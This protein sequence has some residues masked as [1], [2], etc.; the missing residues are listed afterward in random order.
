MPKNEIARN[1]IVIISSYQ[2]NVIENTYRRKTPRITP[3]VIAAIKN[4]HQISVAFVKPWYN[5]FI[6]ILD[7][8]CYC[9]A[10]RISSR[11][12]CVKYPCSIWWSYTDAH[13]SI[14]ASRPASSISLNSITSFSIL[15]DFLF[16]SYS[17]S[18]L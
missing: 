5:F 12:S 1:S 14:N 10:V 13:A 8:S 16:C 7:P 15:R 4:T 6:F 9:K 11:S 18:S 2:T 17:S 3:T